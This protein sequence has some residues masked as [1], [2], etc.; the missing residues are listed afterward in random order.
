MRSGLTL[1]FVPL[2][3]PYASRY[4]A[5]LSLS[6]SLS[7]FLISFPC[8]TFTPSVDE[9]FNRPPLG[10]SVFW[11]GWRVLKTKR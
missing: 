3:L 1:R 5:F 10:C 8:L 9:L 6:L 4:A 2:Y 11:G 7:V